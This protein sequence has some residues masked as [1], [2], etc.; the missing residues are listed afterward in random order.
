LNGVIAYYVLLAFLCLFILWPFRKLPGFYRQSLFRFRKGRHSPFDVIL[1]FIVILPVVL[2]FTIIPIYYLNTFDPESLRFGMRAVSWRLTWSAFYLLYAVTLTTPVLFIV[3]SAGWQGDPHSETGILNPMKKLTV[4]ILLATLVLGSGSLAYEF[5]SFNSFDYDM[6]SD[7]V[8]FP[9]PYQWLMRERNH[10]EDISH[11]H[12]ETV[13]FSEYQVT[14]RFS[15]V[16]TD[17][18]EGTF[19]EKRTAP[20]PF[21]GGILLPTSLT[22]LYESRPGM[23]SF[24]NDDTEDLF[25]GQMQDAP[26]WPE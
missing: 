2:L 7:Y 9:G 17:G 22:D 6:A 26:E 16:M 24:A 15:V 19:L 13:T 10:V 18:R 11:V 5:R 12:I 21:I 4:R 8:V 1:L 14:I 20:I 25:F 23:F 3:A